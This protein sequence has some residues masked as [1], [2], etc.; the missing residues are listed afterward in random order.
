MNLK[1]VLISLLLI[2]LTSII[3][4]VI[5]VTGS[6]QNDPVNP[7][8]RDFRENCRLLGIVARRSTPPDQ[9]FDILSKFKR[10]SS[11]QRNGWSLS[12]Y[13]NYSHGGLLSVPGE[14]MIIRSERDV[15]D[16]Q[17]IYTAVSQLM[18]R[19]RPCLMIGHLR[20]SSSGCTDVADPHPFHRILHGTHYLMIHNGGVWGEDLKV[21]SDELVGNYGQPVNCPD[22]PIDSEY[23]FLYLMKLIDQ[24]GLDPMSACESWA[25]SL[26]TH[27]SDEWNAL[28]ILFTDGESIYGARISYQMSSF[29]LYY[30]ELD[31][32]AGYAISTQSLGHG[33]TMI[34]NMTTFRF[35]AGEPATIRK[36]IIPQSIPQT[37][38]IIPPAEPIQIR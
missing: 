11:P 9:I 5:Q 2:S 27:F 16:D 15:Y 38:P 4:M 8:E 20:N 32:M 12:T 1:K 33:W 34:P 19:I 22:M 6:L 18:V 10:P 23:L 24:T 31:G 17:D 21:L 28:N 3:V 30:S 37:D 25:L 26:L 35:H 14:P 13:S 36:I 29:F 7:D